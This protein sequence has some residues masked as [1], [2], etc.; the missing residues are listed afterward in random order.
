MRLRSR[1]PLARSAVDVA[2]VGSGQLIF[3][4]NVT[5]TNSIIVNIGIILGSIALI[6]PGILLAIRWSVAAQVAAAE[7]TSWSDALRRSGAL[8]RGHYGHVFEVSL[9]VGLL[10]FAL[11]L[12]VGQ[13]PLGSSAGVGS[14]IVGIALN[15]VTVSFGALTIALLYFDLLARP[16]AAP[17]APREHPHLRDLD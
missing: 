2:L 12:A 1:L 15:T 3:N 11:A 5:I 13:A 17:A 7:R 6:V 16:K 9:T 8:T 14:V 10:T 4:T